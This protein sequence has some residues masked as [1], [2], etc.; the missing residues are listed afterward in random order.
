MIVCIFGNRLKVSAEAR[1]S[2][3]ALITRERHGQNLV[4]CL[5]FLDRLLGDTYQRKIAAED[6]RLSGHGV[7][8]ILGWIDVED[9]LNVVFS[10][11]CIGK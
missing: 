7:G 11:L 4:D 2:G 3:G 8:R 9:V 5:A 1:S 6:L 10:N